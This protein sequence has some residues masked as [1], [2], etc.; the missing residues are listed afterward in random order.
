MEQQ[1]NEI[2]IERSQSNVKWHI[3]LLRI[4][5]TVVSIVV[6]IVWFGAKL[7]KQIALNQQAIH[8]NYLTNEKIMTN[9]LPHIQQTVNENRELLIELKTIITKT[10]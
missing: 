5:I 9:H 1:T 8:A 6:T 7:D 3:E 10:H 2:T 4:G